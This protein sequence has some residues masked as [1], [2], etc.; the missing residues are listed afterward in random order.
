MDR[1]DQLHIAPDRALERLE[2]RRKMLVRNRNDAV[3][4]WQQKD[5]AAKLNHLSCKLISLDVSWN[6]L[7]NE[8]SKKIQNMSLCLEKA[9]A[10]LPSLTALRASGNQIPL[11]GTNGMKALGRGCEKGT[12]QTLHTHDVNKHTSI[13]QEEEE[14]N[15]HQTSPTNKKSSPLSVPNILMNQYRIG[16]GRSA[17]DAIESISDSLLLQPIATKTT[18][19]NAIALQQQQTTSP[20]KTTPT[21]TSSSSSAIVLSSKTKTPERI[22][23]TMTSSSMHNNLPSA[24]HGLP[25]PSLTS[26]PLLIINASNSQLS[27][28]D[29]VAMAEGIQTSKH[30]FTV[31]EI[32]I[33]NN[34]IW[35]TTHSKTLGNPSGYVSMIQL[36]GYCVVL[37]RLLLRNNVV[38]SA[39][40]STRIRS[41]ISTEIGVK[42]HSLTREI[43]KVPMTVVNVLGEYLIKRR[44]E[45]M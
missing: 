27:C 22:P 35:H 37:E 7:K 29:A 8:D 16:H 15:F 10:Y 32:N 12:I 33:S 14:T 23:S 31:L 4:K 43:W 25:I 34:R 3:V 36:A 18:Q 5:A 11:V 24:Y 40:D 19:P 38:E 42:P 21:T 45:P 2:Y 6:V 41:V 20:H 44:S 39:V 30:R 28:S 1:L 26:N 13:F 17:I 9:L